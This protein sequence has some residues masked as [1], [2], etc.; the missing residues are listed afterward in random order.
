ML[1]F[2]NLDAQSAEPY[3]GVV[4]LQDLLGNPGT[5]SRDI[6]IQ[7]GL[8]G[9]NIVDIPEQVT[10]PKGSS[11]ATFPISANG[12]KG[13]ATIDASIKGVMGTQTKISTTSNDPRLKIFT[14]GIDGTIKM[15]EPVELTVFVDD[16]SANAVSG[17][18]IKFV[19]EPGVTISPENTRTDESG[20]A[21]VDVTVTKGELV[22]IQIMAS[23]SG[24]SEGQQSFDYQVAGSSFGSLELGLPDWVLYVGVAAMVGIGAVLVVFLK[25]P[26]ESSVD[27]DEDYEYEYEEEI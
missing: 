15:G 16:E 6:K 9:T 27:E 20:S 25:K 4:Q 12:Q 24:Y 22:S 19:T 23:A 3:D 11:Y 26:K 2:E 14:E 18:A 21:K 13:D 5:A 8:E 1:P 17:A 7:L 10:I